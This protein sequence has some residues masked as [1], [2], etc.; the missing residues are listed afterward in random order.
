MCPTRHRLGRLT[1]ANSCVLK[2]STMVWSKDIV[3]SCP[4][5]K[6]ATG[7]F[8]AQGPH[9]IEKNLKLGF[10]AKKFEKHCNIEFLA[11]TEG[12]YLAPISD[13]LVNLKLFDNFGDT[14]GLVDL[15]LSDE[16]FRL[17][18]Y[19]EDAQNVLYRECTLLLTNLKLLSQHDDT[20]MRIFDYNNN[21][22]TVYASQNQIFLPR[23]IKI[24]SIN[25][26]SS[27]KCYRDV[28][29]TFQLG[30]YTENAFLSQDRIIRA[31]STEIQ[32][33]KFPRYITLPFLEKTIVLFNQQVD[34]VDTRKINFE[35]FDFYDHFQYK[36]LTHVDG[37]LK[38]VNIL[39]QIHNLSLTNEVGGEWLVI[40]SENSSEDKVYAGL[41][42]VWESF[43]RVVGKIFKWI[44]CVLI[45]IIGVYVMI[46]VIVCLCESKSC[47]NYGNSC[48]ISLKNCCTKK[49]KPQPITDYSTNQPKVREHTIE[50]EELLMPITNKIVS[51]PIIL[52]STLNVGRSS[53]EGHNSNLNRDD[54]NANVYD[55]FPITKA[56]KKKSM[57]EN[58]KESMMKNFSH[59][60]KKPLDEIEEVK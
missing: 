18:E 6:V 3:Q 4:F 54:D 21:E 55:N 16:D 11:T 10:Q 2:D 30:D 12:L 23:C 7:A 15:I 57:S 53:S 19:E 51:E 37:L 58:F 36:N 43:K 41:E 32:C 22:V 5:K 39:G 52:G 59:W 48:C 38:G 60:T 20:F 9:I 31:Y 50:M 26:V 1:Y 33:Q 42:N 8:Q 17:I 24:K 45:S 28:P 34:I 35:N 56:L 14:R 46:K 47:R 29:I 27:E 49:P 44:I 40:P 25:I 13:L